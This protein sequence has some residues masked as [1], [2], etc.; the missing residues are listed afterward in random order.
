MLKLKSKINL[1]KVPL[2]V[3]LAVDMDKD[4]LKKIADDVIARRTF[5]E[6]SRKPWE[7]I[8]K[9][10]MKLAKLNKE[11]KDYPFDNA[12]NIKHPLLTTAALQFAART[13]PEIVRHGE[14][15]HT[16][17][18][19]DDPQNIKHQTARVIA[20]HMNYQLLV[21]SAEWEN[22]LDKLLHMY[23]LTGIAFKKTYYDPLKQVNISEMIPYDEVV[24]NNDIKS[25]E[26]ARR[27]TH[28]LRMHKN[29]LLSQMRN[30]AY[31]EIDHKKLDIETVQYE[32]KEDMEVLEQHRYLDLDG[33]GYEEP[34]VVTVLT[35]SADVLRI[36]GRWDSNMVQRNSKNKVTC[37]KPIHYFTDY[38]FIPNPD[39][40]YYS[41]GFGHLLYNL[42][43]AMNTLVNQITDAGTLANIQGGL[44]GSDIRIKGGDLKVKMGQYTKLDTA[45]NGKINDSIHTFDFKPPSPVSLQLLSILT[46]AAKELASITD[47]NTGQSQVQNVA[48]GVMAAQLEAGL[49]MFTGIQRRLFRSLKKEFEKLYRLNSI[50]LP[51]QV[52]FMVP[53]KNAYISKDD[54]SDTAIM[55]KPV[56]DPNMASD[57]MRI[58]QAQAMLEAGNNPLLMPHMNGFGVGQRYF[59]ALGIDDVGQVLQPPDPNAPPPPEILQIQSDMA[60]KQAQIQLDSHK[61]DLQQQDVMIRAHVAESETEKNAAQSELFRAQAYAA[62]QQPAL[63]QHKQ[64][65][66]AIRDGHKARLELEKEHVKGEVAVKVAKA[67]PKPSPSEK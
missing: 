51:P 36:M 8:T 30:G 50:Y 18:V 65:M 54:Y 57:E 37:I 39:G 10:V 28:V 53:G 46:M 7:N 1:D 15:V 29:D 34:Y 6:Q 21:E 33:D 43:H 3:N 59:E 42:T 48:T 40:S 31:L 5:D 49:K 20:D 22:S 60:H 32:G 12:S 17:V 24:I 63:E 56:A 55:I 9:K 11:R 26:E 4:D 38:H 19:G 16:A 64:A 44:L 35:H 52:Q 45:L 47:T 2:S 14:V 41:I 25:L 61:L 58:R 66:D 67:K 13:Y 27:I 23:A 62:A